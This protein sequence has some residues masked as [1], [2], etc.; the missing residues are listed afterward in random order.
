VK[1]LEFKDYYQILGVEK[2]ASAEGIKKVYRKLAKQYHP[3]SNKSPDA[4]R[5][6]KELSEAYTVLSDPEKRQKYDTLGSNWNRHRETGGGQDDF[7]W[8]EYFAQNAQRK[9]GNARQKVGDMFGGD[10]GGISDFFERIFGG[11]FT[12]GA[13]PKSQTP[14][15]KGENFK[16]E[17]TVTFEESY[18]GTKRVLTVNDEKFEINLKPGLYEGQTLKISGK[19]KP[20]QDGSN[21]GDL[22]IHIKVEEDK[23][24]KKIGNDLYFDIEVDYLTAI[25]G[26]EITVST[27]AGKVKINITPNSKAGK[28][29]KLKSMGMPEY[30]NP[31]NRGDLFLKVSIQIP[32]TFSVEE[33]E[34]IKQLKALR[35]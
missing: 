35:K 16:T 7:N 14:K 5:K 21:A 2:N 25:L 34:I 12:G 4:E 18:K 6:F 11:G 15:M 23:R 31:L 1:N 9:A 8:N 33:L 19:G 32:E 13:K 22:I 3:D 26:G 29:L 20:S 30:K 27:I 24:Y 28:L 10:S 17:V